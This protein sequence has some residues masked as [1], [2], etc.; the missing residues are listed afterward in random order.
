MAP[1]NAGGKPAK[2]SARRATS[3]TVVPVL[4][5]N[6]PQRPVNRQ[7]SVPAKSSPLAEV[8]PRQQVAEKHQPDVKSS[9]KMTN[10][11]SNGVLAETLDSPGSNPPEEVGSQDDEPT[12]IPAPLTVAPASTG[13]A[14]A[15]TPLAGASAGM[16]LLSYPYFPA[17]VPGQTPHCWPLHS[18]PN[19]WR[20]AENRAHQGPDTPTVVAAPLGRSVTSPTP[21]Q[22]SGT[23]ASSTNS[24]SLR[25][26]A[27]DQ[28]TLAPQPALAFRP[29]FHQAHPSN[30]SMIFGGFQDSNASSPAPHSGGGFPPPDMM[31]Y[32]PVAPVDAYGRPLLVSPTLDGYPPAVI[33]H[34]GP[35]TPHSFHG[36]QVSAQAEDHSHGLR[37]AANGVNGHPHAEVSLAAALP[38]MNTHV[39]GSMQAATGA[40]TT[41]LRT[42]VRDQEE[43]ALNFLRSAIDEPVYSD[44]VLEVVCM[45]LAHSPASF[46][47]DFHALR[48]IRIPAH[49]LIL[50]RSRT[51]TAILN[52]HPGAQGNVIR[53]E[54]QGKHMRPDVFFTAIRTL[55]GWPLADNQVFPTDLYLRDVC[56]DFNLALSYITMGQYLE[57]RWVYTI[58]MLRASQLL[59]WDTLELAAE[60]VLPTNISA[61]AR[62]DPYGTMNL[63]GHILGFIVKNF[64]KDFTLDVN[65]GLAGFNR[66]PAVNP[67]HVPRPPSVVNGSSG[68]TH[69]RQLSLQSNHPRGGQRLSANPRLSQIKFG[70]ISPQNQQES[71]ATTGQNGTQWRRAPTAH[72]TVLSK[73]LLN[74][75]YEQLKQ[76][77]EDHNL[78][79]LVGGID[80][81]M[82]QSIIT[83]IIAEREARRLRTLDRSQTHL[84]Y[85][86]Q[87]A[88]NCQAPLLV[89]G[90]SDFFVNNMG[91]KEEVC[92]GDLPF[93]VHTWVAQVGF[94]T[95]SPNTGPAC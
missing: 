79:G 22:P 92:T 36:S 49:R 8:Q 16:T 91:F 41:A 26:P 35:P 69:S 30:G 52:S 45:D 86:Q 38:A 15:P 83:D 27:Y 82:R 81:V 14:A 76:V 31:H 78:A 53:I 62:H 87:K 66:L 95:T 28:P 50:S 25:G 5:L 20:Q 48:P 88:A 33:N 51:L 56:D 58:A 23:Q 44:V 65:A 47:P 74:L 17:V 68:G 57:L 37:P 4:P 43:D 90:M 71:S 61:R 42:A 39:N 12:P 54:L 75:P 72:E 29:G 55:Y 21:T 40:S 84:H 46:H 59:F 9:D 3:N 67:S 24:P 6:Y 89:E 18:A 10:N 93:L 13:C 85:L 70:D 1:S 64:P 34:H 32:P 2:T 7:I 63:L 60:F 11:H 73:I 80:P 19:H 94:G 77:L